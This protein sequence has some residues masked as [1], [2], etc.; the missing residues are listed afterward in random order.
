MS[1]AMWE[2]CSTGIDVF[3]AAKSTLVHLTCQCACALERGWC[4]TIGQDEHQQV[5]GNSCSAASAGYGECQVQTATAAARRTTTV[6]LVATPNPTRI[7][8]GLNNLLCHGD[9]S[10][11]L[12]C[13]QHRSEAG[14]KGR[15]LL[16]QRWH[17]MKLRAVS[18][19]V[20]HYLHF[21]NAWP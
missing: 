15:C 12:R 9:L 16:T 11:V 2:N 19:K 10:V 14:F 3:R 7:R 6:Q 21:P 20:R 8:V 5:H 17:A 18:S 4:G 1:T 13:Q